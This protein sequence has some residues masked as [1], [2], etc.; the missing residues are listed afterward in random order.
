ME[1]DI[2]LERQY[3][4]TYISQLLESIDCV[5]NDTTFD[6]NVTKLCDY[7]D[8]KLHCSQDV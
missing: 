7:C 6:K 1:N 8:F 2:I 4:D 3:L 5:E